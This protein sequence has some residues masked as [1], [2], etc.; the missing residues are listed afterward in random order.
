MIDEVK[1]TD[2]IACF[3]HCDKPELV[4]YLQDI[5]MILQEMEEQDEEMEEQ[6]QS[7]AEPNRDE[8]ESLYLGRKR[9]RQPPPRFR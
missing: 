2:M 9:F 6:D 5:I 1:L 7:D 3:L 8:E 4:D